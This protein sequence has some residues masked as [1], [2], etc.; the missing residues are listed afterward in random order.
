MLDSLRWRHCSD[1]KICQTTWR[2]SASYIIL[3][4]A[5][6]GVLRMLLVVCPDSEIVV[7]PQTQEGLPTEQQIC[8]GGASHIPENLVTGVDIERHRRHALHGLTHSSVFGVSVRTA[9]EECC[10]G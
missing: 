3:T 9:E 2:R 4:L 5:V 6:V 7:V 8:V 1:C 10:Q